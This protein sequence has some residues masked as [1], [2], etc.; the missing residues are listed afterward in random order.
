MSL[1]NDEVHAQV[2]EMLASMDRQVMLRLFMPGTCQTC[3]EIERLVKEVAQLS[4]HIAVEVISL[5]AE[6]QAASRHQIEAGPALTLLAKNEAG[7]W[8]D[9]GVV[10]YGLPSGYEFTSL[11]SALLTVSSGETGLHPETR[12]FLGGL[13][14]DIEIKVFVTPTCPYCPQAVVLAHRL[15]VESP[16]VRASMVEAMEFP[17]WSS[18]FGVSG[19]PHSVVDGH[20][21]FVGALPEPAMR[22][23]LRKAL[24]SLELPAA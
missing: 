13:R 3:D 20:F 11:I 14:E 17:D 18:E 24:Q 12:A 16:H 9:Y 1:L 2:R 4:D 7:Q 5:E 8:I 6:P 23:E 15:A 10:F 21:H 22:D 19:V